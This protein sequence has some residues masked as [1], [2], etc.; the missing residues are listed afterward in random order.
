MSFHQCLI[1][2]LISCVSYSVYVQ[3]FY[4]C[5]VSTSISTLLYSLYLIAKCLSLNK[6]NITFVFKSKHILKHWID[7]DFLNNIYILYISMHKQTQEIFCTFLF[8]QYNIEMLSFVNLGSCFIA[9]HKHNA[10]FCRAFL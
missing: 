2:N 5:L 1:L 4:F 9:C 7:V 8:Y 6:A 3:N 10:D